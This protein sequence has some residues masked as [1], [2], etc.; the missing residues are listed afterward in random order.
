MVSASKDSPTNA[1]ADEASMTAM[2]GNMTSAAKGLPPLSPVMEQNGATPAEFRNTKV[3][4]HDSSPDASRTNV[5]AYVTSIMQGNATSEIDELVGTLRTFVDEYVHAAEDRLKQSTDGE[6]QQE[7]SLTTGSGSQ[8]AQV[9][10]TEIRLDGASPGE[11]IRVNEFLTPSTG[12]TGGS[13]NGTVTVA[14]VHEEE[15]STSSDDGVNATLTPMPQSTIPAVRAMGGPEDTNFVDQGSFPG[16]W[17]TAAGI[18]PESPDSASSGSGL[19]STPTKAD[20]EHQSGSGKLPS[21]PVQN[22]GSSSTSEVVKSEDTGVDDD[23]HARPSSLSAG[24]GAALLVIICLKLA[25]EIAG[26]AV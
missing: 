26:V 3:A 13:M 16:F 23:S 21:T 7:V 1:P 12:G 14:V 22:D 6:N 19:P 25:A 4:T 5:T 20:N 18:L 10:V 15:A 8:A 11:V 24:A 2:S 17:D 9:L